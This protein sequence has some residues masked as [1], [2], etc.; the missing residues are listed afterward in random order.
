MTD[1]DIKKIYSKIPKPKIYEDQTEN[2]VREWREV[3]GFTVP[4]HSYTYD[5]SKVTI[6]CKVSFFDL[7]LQRKFKPGEFQEV[8]TER[9]EFLVDKLRAWEYV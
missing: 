8:D 5:D 1:K 9:A 6:K 4:T 3:L 7:V 2:I